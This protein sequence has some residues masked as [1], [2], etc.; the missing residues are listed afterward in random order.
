MKT[1]R[2]S[3]EQQEGNIQPRPRLD[4][5][6]ALP[7]ETDILATEEFMRVYRT[8]QLSPEHE[9]AVAILELAV[10]DYQRYL[11]RCD[12]KSVKRFTEAEA[13]I[14]ETD[15]EWIFSFVNCCEVLGIEPG[16]LRQGL[17]DWKQE[18]RAWAK[19]PSIAPHRKMQKRPFLSAA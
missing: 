15:S 5:K 19:S 3:K 18:N 7:F 11:D 10:A 4:D 2:R 13:W 9:L 17:L 8:H 14:L 1:R 6:P 16:Y 12:K